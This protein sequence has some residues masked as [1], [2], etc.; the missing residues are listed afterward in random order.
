MK[1]TAG[2]IS[3]FYFSSTVR[4]NFDFYIYGFCM[5]VLDFV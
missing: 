4:G 1:T 3:H 5:K 2:E